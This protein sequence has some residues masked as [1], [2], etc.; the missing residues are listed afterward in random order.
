MTTPVDQ[1]SFADLVQRFGALLDEWHEMGAPGGGGGGLDAAGVATLPMATAADTNG[2]LQLGVAPDGI[3]KR[4]APAVIPNPIADLPRAV[5]ALGTDLMEISRGGTRTGLP[6]S[7]FTRLTTGKI[8]VKEPPYN[9]RGDYR[10]VRDGVVDQYSTTLRSASNPFSPADVGKLI[11]IGNRSN[12]RATMTRTIAAYVSPGEITFGPAP[13]GSTGPAS[14]GDANLVIGWGTDDTAGMRLALLAAA[15]PAG[16][17]N[18][19]GG[20]LE[21]PPGFYLTDH[22][23][24]PTKTAIVG[25]GP[26][27][28]VFV[29]KP[30]ASNL[31]TLSNQNA[32]DDFPV[33]INLGIYG[34]KVLQAGTQRGYSYAATAPFGSYFYVAPYPHW[35][36][37]HVW[38]TSGDG[39]VHTGQGNGIMTDVNIADCRGCGFNLQGFDMDIAN[40]YV[41]GC[42]NSAIFMEYGAAGNN[43][44]NG[45]FS[46]SAGNSFAQ[47]TQAFDVGALVYIGFETSGNRFN[48]CRAQ[49]SF[50]SCW[51]I[52][53][54]HNHLIGCGSEDAG[55]VGYGPNVQPSNRPR[56]GVQLLPGATDCMIDVHHSYAIPF[57]NPINRSTHAFFASNATGDAASRATWNVVNMR[58]LHTMRT[59]EGYSNGS[60]ATDGRTIPPTTGPY[61][62]ALYGTDDPGGIDGT[63]ELTINRVAIL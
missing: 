62:R 19:F 32:I 37:I 51:V 38:E 45:K 44:N 30:S 28:S 55:N 40:I 48:N 24:L 6:L 3:P 11:F 53:G 20:A 7:A 27:Q 4:F 2:A 13:G 57:S 18:I 16:A 10:E 36:G 5:E 61:A 23:Y 25:Y 42:S 33:L 26:R 8:N 52:G 22:L 9:C 29:R 31:P 35:H 63:N 54:K 39:I 34:L 49:E 60:P 15:P 56:A 21:V 47:T 14:Y 43:I 50:L 59:D 1:A 46:Y 17:K 41:L 12:G 58:T